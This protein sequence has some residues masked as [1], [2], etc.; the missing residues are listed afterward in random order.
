M[1]TDMPAGRQSGST[2]PAR[3]HD[4]GAH[5]DATGNQARLLAFFNKV[6][7]KCD[8]PTPPK[9]ADRAMRLT[10]DPRV[11]LSEVARVVAGD[12]AL[13]A[14]V[15][16]ISRSATYL[17]RREPPRTVDA[18]ITTVGFQTVR[19][20]LVVAAARS[21][22]LIEDRVA[23]ELWNHALATAIAA[24]EIGQ[25]D[26]RPRGG[27]IFVAG[28]LHDLGKLVFH[29]SNRGAYSPGECPDDASEREAFGVTHAE[30]GSCLV[31]RWDLEAVV[32]TAIG[33]HHVEPAAAGAAG[34]VA[35]ADWIAYEIGY[36]AG[37]RPIRPPEIS[38]PRTDLKALVRRT[39]SAFEAEARY[40]E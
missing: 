11:H 20:V 31:G 1:S 32:V 35:L 24:D 37:R 13:A 27:D 10:R 28:L 23:G 3:G 30:V 19:A 18:A 25:L 12:P 29:L 14:Q 36:G 6:A 22:Y 17:G 38:D 39:A 9:V 4:A 7:E 33:Q 5:N 34:C 40:F 2:S 8:L 15:L 16:R 26:A 21:V